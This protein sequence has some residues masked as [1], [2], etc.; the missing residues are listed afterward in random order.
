MN[1]V[2]MD[3]ALSV[4][5][6]NGPQYTII[7]GGGSGRCALLYYGASLG[8][9]TLTSGSAYGGGANGGTL[10]NCLLTGNSAVYG[11]GRVPPP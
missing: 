5:S 6:V 10:N 9:F 4:R 7:D 11:G 2:V 3:K 1:R 8:G